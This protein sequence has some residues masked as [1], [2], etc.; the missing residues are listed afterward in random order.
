M[1]KPPPYAR[2]VTFYVT[3]TLATPT[4]P[5]ASITYH[6]QHGTGPMV[7]YGTVRTAV[8]FRGPID[9]AIATPLRSMVTDRLGPEWRDG[10]FSPAAA[11]S[12]PANDP[13]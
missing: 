10:G 12:D 13:E 9:V 11:P 7:H 1:A 6:S 3:V 5:E 2:R 8:P 4:S